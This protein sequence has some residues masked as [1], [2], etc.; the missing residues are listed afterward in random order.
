MFSLGFIHRFLSGNVYLTNK[1]K[2]KSL[3]AIFQILDVNNDGY[4]QIWELEKILSCTRPFQ[5]GFLGMQDENGA[6]EAEKLILKLDGDKNGG[7]I[8]REKF[9]STL[10]YDPEFVEFQKQFNLSEASVKPGE[11]Y[12]E[13]GRVAPCLGDFLKNK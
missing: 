13:P 9:I 4:L 1:D 7:R 11:F 12:T 6:K 10:F 5:D 8:T 2:R 3:D